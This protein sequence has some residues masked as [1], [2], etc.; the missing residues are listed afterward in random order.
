MCSNMNLFSTCLC[1]YVVYIKNVWLN[2]LE[3]YKKIDG[4]WSSERIT[5]SFN[6]ILAVRVKQTCLV[7]MDVI[8][9]KYTKTMHT[10]FIDVTNYN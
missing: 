5:C 2:S 3:D 7:P 10:I 9:L 8:F 4:Y 6:I 1:M